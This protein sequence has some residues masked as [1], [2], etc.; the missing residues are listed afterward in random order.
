M[1]S[2]M[3]IDPNLTYKNPN[4]TVGRRVHR[5]GYEARRLRIKIA[6][7]RGV[8]NQVFLTPDVGP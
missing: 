7:W 2:Y 1:L 5:I 6:S 3:Y 4:P 8:N